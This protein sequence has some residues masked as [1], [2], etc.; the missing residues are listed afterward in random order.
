MSASPSQEVQ[1][2]SAAL[3][4]ESVSLSPSLGSLLPMALLPSAGSSI[5]SVYEASHNDSDYQRHVFLT[6]SMAELSFSLTGIQF[7]IDTGSEV[8]SVSI[9]DTKTDPFLRPL[10]EERDL[11]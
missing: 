8:Q 3:L 9:N 6:S 7:V 5:Q 11:P 10:W 1:R 2:C 4:T